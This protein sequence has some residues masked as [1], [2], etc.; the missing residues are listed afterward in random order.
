VKGAAAL[1]ARLPGL[2]RREMPRRQ[3]EQPHPGWACR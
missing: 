1:E 3:R 2:V